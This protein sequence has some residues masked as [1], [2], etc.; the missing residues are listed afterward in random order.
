[1]LDIPTSQW[2][3]LEIVAGLGRQSTGRW[4]LTVTLP[5]QAPKRFAD[6]PSHP[7]WKHLGWLGF[8]SNANGPSVFYLDNLSLSNKAP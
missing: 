1:M 5:G 3:R 2:V 4:E 6:L 8:V 7:A